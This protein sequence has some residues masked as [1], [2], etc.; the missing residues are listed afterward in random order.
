MKDTIKPVYMDVIL[1]SIPVD[2]LN[3][4]LKVVI[5]FNHNDNTIEVNIRAKHYDGRS[6]NI[7]ELE[8]LLEYLDNTIL[9]KLQTLFDTNRLYITTS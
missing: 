3:N 8:E 1:K 7:T 4:Y 5:N 2:Y 6:L 9:S